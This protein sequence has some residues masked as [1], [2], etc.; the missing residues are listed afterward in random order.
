MG[1]VA[2][3]AVVAVSCQALT[4]KHGS[5]PAANGQSP[6]PGATGATGTSGAPGV[7]GTSGTSTAPT[8]APSPSP[9]SVAK[10]SVTPGG[11]GAARP[12]HGLAIAVSDGTL[13]KVVAK[14]EGGGE[15]DPGPVEGALNGDKTE[16]HSTWALTTATAYSVTATAVDANGLETSVTK[17]F[18]TLAPTE[19]FRTVIFEG[20]HKTYGVGMPIILNFDRDIEDKAAVERSLTLTTSKPVVGA[21][22]WDGD[23]TLMFRPRGYWPADTTVSFVGHLDGV[24]SGPGVFGVHT[25]TQQFHIGRSLIAVASTQ[26]HH[27]QVYLD[28]KLMGDWPISAGKPGDETPIDTYLTITKANPEEMIGEDYDIMVPWSVRFTWSGSFV[29][30]APWSV[31]EQG[32]I[33]VSHGCVNLPPD[34]AQVYYQLEDPGDPVTVVGSIKA[35]EWDNGW[36]IWFLSWK[37]LLDGTG[38]GQAVKAGPHGSQFVAPGSLHLSPLKSPLQGPKVGNSDPVSA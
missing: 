37:D 5:N 38:T 27:M 23:R 22:Y 14:S 29:H 12:D 31:S 19:D 25:L 13:T 20:Y 7:T 33:N 10:I 9:T 8:T 24:R 34:K 21:W 35:G 1:V 3:V 28:K 17:H 26:T 11:G 6:P 4:S 16:W 18:R 30:A 15:A 32:R 36:T 2:A